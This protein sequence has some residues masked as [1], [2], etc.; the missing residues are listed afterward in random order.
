MLS[1]TKMLIHINYS[2][3]VFINPQYIVEHETDNE[4]N[5]ADAKANRNYFANHPEAQ[6]STHFIVEDKQ[7]IQCAELNWRCWHVGD[8]IG[9]SDI[10]NSNSIGIEI[11]VNADGDYN[12]ARQN[13]IELTKSLI[14]VTGILAIM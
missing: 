7:M 6:A 14:S 3:A 5:G 10:I 12:K 9:H 11:C 4:D 1:I 13:T 2:K 8:N